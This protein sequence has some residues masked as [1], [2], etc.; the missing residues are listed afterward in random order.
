MPTSPVTCFRQDLIVTHTTNNST[1]QYLVKNPTNDCSF[2]FGEEEYFLC[3]SING[4][5]T[6]SQIVAAFQRRFNLALTEADF[7]DFLAQ[8]QD[9][10]LLET[11]H[12]SNATNS[13]IFPE[14]IPKNLQ[15]T[16]NNFD[17]NEQNK[18]ERC[19]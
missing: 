6:T 10:G 8:I 11:Y 14:S 19:K 2:E 12:T 7:Q 17:V 13:L 9:Y 3:Q 18:S 16:S 1:K 15:D 4:T 5:S